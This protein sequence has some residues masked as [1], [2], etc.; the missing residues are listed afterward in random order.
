MASTT[1]PGSTS[2]EAKKCKAGSDLRPAPSGRLPA[3]VRPHAKN[4]KVARVGTASLLWVAPERSSL[5]AGAN[6]VRILPL[7]LC[8]VLA[9]CH[10]AQETSF[11]GADA[12]APANIVQ[13]GARL[14]RVLGCTGCHGPTLQGAAVAQGRPLDGIL[15]ASNLTLV[16]PHYSDSQLNGI[17]RTGVH[18]SRRDLWGM[19]SQIFQ[20][21]SA[22]D[23]DSLVAFLRTV[24]PAGRPLPPPQLDQ[25]DRQR[26]AA[27]ATRPAA[28]LVE[29]F[30]QL[31]PPDLGSRYR[32]GRYIASVTCEGCHGSSLNGDR[33]SRAPDL[34][35]VGA[36]SHDDFMRLMIQGVGAGGRA[37]DPMMTYAAR[38]RFS[39][40]TPTEREALYA[41]LKARASEAR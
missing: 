1:G 18:P 37:L 34:A 10:R 38:G 29:E 33:T 24:R 5:A 40:L 11:D 12:N 8:L 21:L 17:V 9:A 13:H 32:L 31:Q 7:L 39:H 16:L 2:P 26:I 35:I 19:P 23:Y 3:A 6:T 25:I 22:R 27:G 14:S 20:F 15:N 36:Y 4:C 30:R 28:R 41:Y